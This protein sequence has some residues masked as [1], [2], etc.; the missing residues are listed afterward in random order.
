MSNKDAVNQLIADR[1]SWL[2]TEIL[3]MTQ[4]EL[5]KELKVTH[6]HIISQ[7]ERAHLRP[8]TSRCMMLIKLAGRFGKKIDIN[9]LRPDLEN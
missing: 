7:Y 5:A 6:Q 2:R 3:Q 4:E 9:W 8:G 1:M